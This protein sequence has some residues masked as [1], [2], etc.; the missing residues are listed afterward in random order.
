M[1]KK[2]NVL[3]FDINRNRFVEYDVLPYLRRCYD[4]SGQKPIT[5]DEWKQF[6]KR[7]AQYRYWSRCEYEIILVDWPCKKTEK[8]IDVYQQIMMNLD[9]IVDIL[10]SEKAN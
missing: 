6:V 3:N 8:K 9:I 5:K 2:F 1:M 7:E 10:Y 4:E